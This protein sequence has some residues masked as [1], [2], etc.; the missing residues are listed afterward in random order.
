MHGFKELDPGKL[1]TLLQDQAKQGV[2]LI[3]VRTP[4]EVVR[5]Y[6]AGS[7]NI[8][9]HVLPTKEA[10]LDKEKPVIFYC[11]SGGRSAQ[12]CT[13]LAARGFENVYNLTGGFVGWVRAGLPAQS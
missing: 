11:Q 10:E 3:D 7:K 4:A 9:L 12:A 6:I 13:F 1:Q 8:P 5:G 2:I